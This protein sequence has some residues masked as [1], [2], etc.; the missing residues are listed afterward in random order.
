MAYLDVSTVISY[1]EHVRKIENTH[2][3]SDGFIESIEEQIIDDEV[4]T[5]SDIEELND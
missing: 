3:I 4:D 1:H 5:D 2:K